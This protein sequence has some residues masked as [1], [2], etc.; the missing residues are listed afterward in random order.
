MTASMA[1]RRCTWVSDR[2][3]LK[4]RGGELEQIRRAVLLGG[5]WIEQV[6]G[7]D[8][9]ARGSDEMKDDGDEVAAPWRLYSLRERGSREMRGR[10][11]EREGKA[12]EKRHRRR[13]RGPA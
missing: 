10:K 7:A 2:R 12:R 8:D 1:G 5:P 9:M 13:V 6:N 4:R 3:N 11:R